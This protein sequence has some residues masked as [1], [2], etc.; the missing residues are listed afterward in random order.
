[1]IFYEGA[2][3]AGG[4]QADMGAL[5]EYFGLG[6]FF[7]AEG[8]LF[9]AVNG[10]RAALIRYEGMA[11]EY[12]IPQSVTHNGVT[13]T[14]TAVSAYAFAYNNNIRSVYLPAGIANVNRYAFRAEGGEP[15]FI[16]YTALPEGSHEWYAGW[17]GRFTS[18]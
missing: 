4:L 10:N 3:R 15:A 12:T 8:G 7:T 9:A 14:V 17:R 1:M 5:Q 16:I 13:Y 6:S 11:S 18:A 2:H